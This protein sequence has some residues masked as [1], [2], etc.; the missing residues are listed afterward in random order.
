[1]KI[2][3]FKQNLLT[4]PKFKGMKSHKIPTQIV[5][6]SQLTKVKEE[7]I[8]PGTLF[9]HGLI[10]TLEAPV[11]ILLDKDKKDIKLNKDLEIYDCRVSAS[12]KE[13]I[14]K[15]GGKIVK[16]GEDKSDDKKKENK[17]EKIKEEKDKSEK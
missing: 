14:E 8:N 9:K 5:G 10:D 2:R 13:L 11:K 7:K 3:G 17:E 6:L 12:V 15:S 16:S 4:F 1:L